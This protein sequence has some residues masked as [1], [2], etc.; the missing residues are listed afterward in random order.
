MALIQLST[1][2]ASALLKFNDGHD[3]I[4]VTGSVSVGF[5]S[6]IFAS[7]NGGGDIFTNSSLAVEYNRHAGLISVNGEVAWNIGSFQSN[8]GEGFANPSMSLEFVKNNG[9]TTGSATFSASRESQADPTVNV[10]TDSLNYNAGL[11]LKYPVIERYSIAGSVGYGLLDYIDNSAGLSDLSTYTASA[12]LYYAYNSK[13]D[14]FVGYRIRQSESSTTSSSTDHSITAGISGKI[15]A[16]L[17]GN[18]RVGYQIRQ[19]TPSGQTFGSITSSASTTWSVSKRFTL[20]GTLSKDFSTTANESSVDTLSFNLDAQYVFNDHWSVY[21][22]LGVGESQ[23][24]SGS[25]TG[26]QDYYFTW[27]SGISYSLN[28]HFKASFTYSY[29][30]NWSNRSN[31]NFDRN[32]FTLNLTSRW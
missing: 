12:D 16:K 7:K 19:E 20:T 2:R 15:L 3:E 4:F 8:P 6:N 5:D 17:K 31:S 21:S 22:G 27:S 9:R 32:S 30:Q 28:D 11:N 14:L 10:R 23:F 25:D 26:R 13:R 29:F 24:L 1:P 18:V